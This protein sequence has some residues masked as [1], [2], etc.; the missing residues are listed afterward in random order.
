M[1]VN[2]NNPA[3][4]AIKKK[5]IA[6]RSMIIPL[7][8]DISW[9]YA[10]TLATPVPKWFLE[11]LCPSKI[12]QT[13]LFS[14]PILLAG[15]KIAQIWAKSQFSTEYGHINPSATRCLLAGKLKDPRPALIGS[16]GPGGKRGARPLAHGTLGFVQLKELRVNRGKLAMFD[17][18]LLRRKNSRYDLNSKIGL[19]WEGSRIIFCPMILC[20]DG[21]VSWSS[22]G[23]YKY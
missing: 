14:K 19:L 2:P 18:Y 4:I 11:P 22:L 3:I 23:H 16:G 15:G 7:L 20:L 6:Q 12:S 8:R 10:A 17:N 21:E 5:T 1:P 9:D 13:V